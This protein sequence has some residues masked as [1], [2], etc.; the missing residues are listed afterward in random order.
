MTPSQ[1]LKLSFSEQNAEAIQNFESEFALLIFS[2]K[3]F[4]SQVK[5]AFDAADKTIYY[6]DVFYV[7]DFLYEDV[8]RELLNGSGRRKLLAFYK[9]ELY[10]AQQEFRFC[11]RH[12]I[13][14]IQDYGTWLELEKSVVDEAYNDIDIGQIKDSQIIPL[15]SL[16]E[17]G[18]IYDGRGE[19]Q[20]YF[21]E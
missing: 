5:K 15:R 18:M 19:G 6:G 3:T 8:I 4:V 21:V 12:P 1:L 10:R 11:V 13:K 17:N 20:W 2:P 9:N 14:T 16:L 7:N